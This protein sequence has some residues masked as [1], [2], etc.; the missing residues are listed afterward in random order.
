MFGKVDVKK[1]ISKSRTV[2]KYR[3]TMKSLDDRVHI[4]HQIANIIRTN[5]IRAHNEYVRAFGNAIHHGAFPIKCKI[6]VGINQQMLCIIKNSGEKFD[7]KD[8]VA[9]YNA[10]QIYYHHH[11]NGMRSYANNSKLLVDLS[12]GGKQIN[13]YYER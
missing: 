9:K 7:Y 11:G 10:G 5:N 8:V 13:M 6:Y 2:R 3:F 4:Q 1:V 12:H